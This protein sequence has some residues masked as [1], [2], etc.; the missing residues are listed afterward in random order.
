MKP[1]SHKHTSGIDSSVTTLA[2]RCHFQ[3]QK[4]ELDNGVVSSA[5]SAAAASLSLLSKLS[6][7]FYELSRKFCQVVSKIR[8][9]FNMQRRRTT[10]RPSK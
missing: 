8:R 7:E 6:Q 3:A 10:K 4:K 1:G 2:T 9:G 5:A